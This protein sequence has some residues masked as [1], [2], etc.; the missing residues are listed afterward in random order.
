MNSS[1][2]QKSALLKEFEASL[3]ASKQ[4]IFRKSGII[5]KMLSATFAAWLIKTDLIDQ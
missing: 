2:I 3:A 1:S 4:A 5:G